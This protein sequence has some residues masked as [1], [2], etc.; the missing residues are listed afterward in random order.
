MQP[1]ILVVDDASDSWHLLSTILRTHHFHPIWAADTSQAMSEARK[2]QPRAILLNLDL[3]G[4]DGFLMLERLKAS[5]LLAT[6]PV[7]VMT[8]QQLEQSKEMA[9]ELDAAAYLQKPVKAGE[10]VASLQVV[11]NGKE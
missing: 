9:Q 10:L 7:I 11:L 6:V 1:K 5:R 3:P 2:H 8:G 4:L